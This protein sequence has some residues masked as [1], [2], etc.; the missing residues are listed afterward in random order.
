VRDIFKTIMKHLYIYETFSTFIEPYIHAATII[1]LYHN[2]SNMSDKF[3]FNLLT[4][5]VAELFIKI[6]HFLLAIHLQFLIN[7]H[8]L[9]TL[10]QE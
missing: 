9:L 2:I 6:T 10:D 7:V 4:N 3:I 5:V 1:V 8:G